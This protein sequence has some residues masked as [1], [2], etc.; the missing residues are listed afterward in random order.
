MHRIV[1]GG[2]GLVGKELVSH[3]LKQ[4]YR[5][6]VVGRDKKKIVA[7]FGN[8]VR[9]LEFLAVRTWLDLNQG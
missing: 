2:T 9:A 1:A 8:R 6:T 3:W 5:V 4:S 7:E